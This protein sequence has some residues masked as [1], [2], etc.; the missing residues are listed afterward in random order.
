MKLTD[1][2]LRGRTV[3]GSDGL[4]VGEIAALILDSTWRVTSLQVKLRKEV[5][6]RIG[7]ERSMFHRGAME[8]PTSMV[9]SVGDAVVLSMPV[10]GLRQMLPDAAA[11]P[12]A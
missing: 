4:A 12:R 9:Q 11:A 8:I 3:I 1:E 10:D 6:E 5:A 2:N 7:A